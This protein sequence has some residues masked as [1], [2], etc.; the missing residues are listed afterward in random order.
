M[1]KTVVFVL[2][3]LL[4]VFPGAVKADERD[5]YIDGNIQTLFTS[6]DGLLSTSTQAIAQTS[7]GFI[8]IGGYGGLVRYDGKQMVPYAYRHIT[9]ITDLLA[10]VD[11]ALWIATSDK[12]LFLYDNNDFESVPGKGHVSQNI[13]CMAMSPDGVLYLGTSE[14]IATVEDGSVIHIDIPDLNDQEIEHLLCLPDGRLLGITKK[15][16]L[17]LLDGAD[18]T[19]VDPDGDYTLRSVCFNPEDNTFLVGTS[20]NE[21]LVFSEQFELMDVLSMPGLSCINDIRCEE[22]GIWWICAD[23]G[24]GVYIDGALRIQN[25]LMD[26]SVGEMM[27]DAENNYWFVSSRQG[28]LEVSLCQFSDV[29]QSAGLSSMVVNAVQHVGDT[30]YI[31]HDSGLVSLSMSDYKQTEDAPFQAVGNARVRSLLADSEGNLWI[32]TMNKGL[33]C[34]TPEGELVSYNREKYPELLSNNFR[35]LSETDEGI[36]AG[37][38]AGAYIISENTVKN[39]ANHPQELN[40]RILSAEKFGDLFYLGSDGTGIYVLKDG[41][42]TGRY[43][44]KN[45]LS[46]NVIMKEYRSEKYDGVWLVTGNNVDFLD[47]EGNITSISQ[48]P[49]TNNLDLIILENGDAWL[50]TGSGIYWTTEESL[51]FDEEPKYLMYRHDDGLPYEITPNSFPCLSG[52]VLY[53]CGTGGVFTLN[54]DFYEQDSSHFM[55]TVDSIETDGEILFPDEQAPLVLPAD[56]LRIKINAYT[57]SYRTVNPFVFYYLEGFDDKET[58]SRLNSLGDITYTNLR[59]GN[60]TFHYGI[61]DYR[62]GEVVQEIELP[63][64]K[65]FPW[66][67]HP[68]FIAAAA[69]AGLLLVVL[70][71]ALVV[72]VRD[73]RLRHALE[74]EYMQKEKE[75]LEEIAYKDYLTGLFNRNY[76]NVWSSMLLP[77]AAYPVSFVSIDLNNLKMANDTHG[78]DV[79]D[80]LLKNIAGLLSRHFSGEPYTVFRTGGDE[81]LILARGV[82]QDQID[83]I[84]AEMKKDAESY[85]VKDVPLTFSYGVCSQSEGEFDFDEG[86]KN[87]DMEMFKEKNKFHGRA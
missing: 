45:G 69:A 29:S 40:F 20:G 70:T 66:Y 54:T 5:L 36:L 30:L 4:L 86:L 8:W 21:I 64:A 34:Y 43:T 17:F 80:Q 37:T 55:L 25:L 14:G 7:E 24:V 77:G 18:C 60:Y 13:D 74:D 9:R 56:V 46:S 49:S 50:L 19:A 71:A 68:A 16:L 15:G 42:I 87:S 3:L 31:G 11:G 53:L 62:T 84:M 27:T 39:I 57:L 72:R 35:S 81:F 76:I 10:G 85:S 59:G 82:G 75:H 12:G 58:V 22:S 6:D 38:D 48:F 73:R 2:M 83:K 47:S 44:A 1:K 33:F 23:D 26:N 61:R 51:L 67:L 65:K 79:G 28:V 52:D 41:E 63:F 32:G 78:H